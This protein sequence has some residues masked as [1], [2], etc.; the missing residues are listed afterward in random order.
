MALYPVIIRNATVFDGS[1]SPPTKADIGI[2]GDQFTAVGDLSRESAAEDIDASGLY[3][4]PGFI[5]ITNHS[6]TH[7]TLFSVPS[8]ESL[9]RQ[10]IT[11]IIGGNC[12]TSL[13]P[14]I[15]PSDIE[16]IQKWTGSSEINVN[17]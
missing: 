8:Q 13:A 6:D 1:G 16:E 2:N 17:W 11:T 5:D 9:L 12:G 10:G 4:A 3:V 14:I 7:W 15:K